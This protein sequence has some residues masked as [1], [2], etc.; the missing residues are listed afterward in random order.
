MPYHQNVPGQLFHDVPRKDPTLR[1]VEAGLV[2]SGKVK[3][4]T[5]GGAVTE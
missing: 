5:N 1:K 2:K 3:A 4:K